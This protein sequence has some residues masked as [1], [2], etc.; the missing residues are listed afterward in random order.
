MKDWRVFATTDL[1]NW[2]HVGTISPADNY[3]GAG[4]TDCWASDAAERNGQH[5]FY[6]SDQKRSVGVMTGPTPAGPFRDVL[7]QPLVAPRHD[8]TA[9][10]DDD[11]G[12]TP[13]LLYGDK[14][15]SFRI[16]RLNENMTSLAETPRPLTITG[17]EWA[18]APEWMDKSYLFKY[19]DTYYLS[20]GR[21]YATSD[22]VYG[23]YVGRGPVGIGHHLNQYAHGSF[24]WWKGQF[25][26]VWCYYLQQGKKYRETIISYAHFT[27]DGRLVT[28]T[29]F[30]DAHF[31]NGVGRYDAGWDRIEAEWYYEIPTATSATKQDAPGAGFQVAN[32]QAGDWLRYANVDFSKGVTESTA[33]LSSTEV[34]TRIEV[35][36]DGIDGEKLGEILVPAT[37]GADAF[38][39]VSTAVSPINGVHDLYLTVVGGDK[40][41]VGLDWFGFR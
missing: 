13:Y 19:Q 22:N 36:I 3:M 40:G 6:F 31:A 12:N 18:Q 34:G 41:G 10:I 16:A 35:R 28:D 26:H 27:N 14:E 5:Y 4:A 29:G 39:A 17:E 9:F 11:A 33:C 32:L 8:P 21:D 15:V 23:P 30:L 25:Y 2:Q 7:G 24:F 38:R 1:V 20:W 37:G